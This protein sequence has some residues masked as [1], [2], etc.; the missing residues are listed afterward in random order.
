[1]GEPWAT[2]VTAAIPSIIVAWIAY[3]GSTAN[4]DSTARQAE[5]S[6][7]DAQVRAIFDLQM[8]DNARLR[9]ENAELT[10]AASHLLTIA[11]RWCDASHE[12]RHGR[13]ND[14]AT[15]N[16]ALHL[17][18]APPVD[19]PAVQPLPGFEEI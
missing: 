12:L 6:R 16:A 17:H 5:A 15:A 4:S 19:W 13:L 7:L 10:R 18:G 3:R 9:A 8:Q 2:L 14:R 11:R 1:M